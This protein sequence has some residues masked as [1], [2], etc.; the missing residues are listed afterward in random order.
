MLTKISFDYL[1]AH[2]NLE[3]ATPA[4]PLSTANCTS[5]AEPYN[6]SQSSLVAPTST[7][8]PNLVQPLR[9]GAEDRG[10]TMNP[11]HSVSLELCLESY[12]H[13]IQM[14]LVPRVGES[15][16]WATYSPETHGRTC[17]TRSWTMPPSI[18]R[19]MVPSLVPDWTRISMTRWRLPVTFEDP[20]FPLPLV[21]P[22]RQE[23]HLQKCWKEYT[24]RVRIK[25]MIM[26]HYMAFRKQHWH[27]CSI[28]SQH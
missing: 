5:L 23:R 17:L 9:S 24:S 26:R 10:L 20:P 13:L 3:N 8:T 18:L 15:L 2:R 12:I 16:F 6:L 25:R 14:A 19:L 22:G 1:V 28:S 21:K 27:A 7:L 4:G 11:Q